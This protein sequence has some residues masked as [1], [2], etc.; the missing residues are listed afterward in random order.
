[1]T[2]FQELLLSA[3]GIYLFGVLTGVI[4]IVFA[5]YFYLKPGGTII[6]QKDTE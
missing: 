1:M 6:F 3:L 4:A 2:D 5:I